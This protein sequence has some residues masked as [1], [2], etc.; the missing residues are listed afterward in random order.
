M[1]AAVR[2][3]RT[4]L[5]VATWEKV[6]TLY[7]RGES[8][9]ELAKVFKVNHRTIGERAAQYG[10]KRPEKPKGRQRGVRAVSASE[11]PLPIGTEVGLHETCNNLD[12]ADAQN[13]QQGLSKLPSALP[14]ALSESP[15][16][17]QD[18]VARFAESLMIQGSASIEPP[19]TIAEMKMLNEIFRK[20][21]GMD[22]KAKEAG[23]AGLVRPM[24]T[25]SRRSTQVVDLE[26]EIDVDRML[27]E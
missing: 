20:A 24:R 8:N 18:Q 5:S 22:Q 9:V 12:V 15:E 23:P 16:A 17:F 11:S 10:W 19:K 2:K 3:Q 7:E 14:Y 26:E 25:L 6:Q 4:V 21:K 13:L 1:Q 27:G